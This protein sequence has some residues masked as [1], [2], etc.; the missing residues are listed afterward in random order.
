MPNGQHFWR[1]RRHFEAFADLMAQLNKKNKEPL[2]LRATPFK[3]NAGPSLL[4]EPT[5]RIVRPSKER[6]IQL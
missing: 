2:D 6:A 3:L 1:E 5:A 4:L